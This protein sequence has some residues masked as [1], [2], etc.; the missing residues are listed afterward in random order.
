M[1]FSRFVAK[2]LSLA[3]MDAGDRCCSLAIS[4]SDCMITSIFFGH[5]ILQDAVVGLS[6]LEN[7]LTVS[8]LA[9][10]SAGCRLFF[11]G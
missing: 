11:C 9:G 2:R 10:L 1:T 7:C 5:K 3:Q 4:C 8:R 6:D